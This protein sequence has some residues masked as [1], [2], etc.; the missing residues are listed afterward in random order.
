MRGWRAAPVERDLVVWANAKLNVTCLEEEG[1]AVDVAYPD[2]SKAFDTNSYGILP[3]KLAVQGLDRCSLHCA[4]NW[5][6]SCAQSM[7]E[8]GSTSSSRL[9]TTG[10]FQGSVLGPVLFNILIYDLD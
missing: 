9:V 6:Y 10:V 4:K 5:G 7:E 8:N 1:K 3:E 2:F